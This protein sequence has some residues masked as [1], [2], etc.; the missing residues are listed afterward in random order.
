[1]QRWGSH[2]G[3]LSAGGHLPLMLHIPRPAWRLLGQLTTHKQVILCN[4]RNAFGFRTVYDFKCFSGQANTRTI[5]SLAALNSSWKGQSP[6]VVH[7]YHGS[8]G[9]LNPQAHAHLHLQHL[10]PRVPVHNAAQA[11]IAAPALCNGRTHIAVV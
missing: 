4:A 1:M 8:I 9:G 3:Q 7:A 6:Q 10:E 11:S 5:A 2:A